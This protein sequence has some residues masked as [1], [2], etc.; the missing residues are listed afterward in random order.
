MASEEKSDDGNDENGHSL[1]LRKPSDK[2]SLIVMVYGPTGVGKTTFAGTFPKPIFLNVERGDES[3]V[4]TPLGDK[5]VIADIENMDDFKEA[6]G[7]IKQGEWGEMFETVVIDSL[8]EW[9]EH[10]MDSILEEQGKNYPTLREWGIAKQRILRMV[11]NIKDLRM[12]LVFICGEKEE[13]DDGVVVKRP[14]LSG[15]DIPQR[16]GAA[17]DVVGYFTAEK[18]ESG[19]IERDIHIEPDRDYYAKHRLGD[20]IESPIEP[21]FDVIQKA[22]EERRDE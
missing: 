21:D 9:Q 5:E 18:D 8:T 6:W 12:N 7:R 15:G 20:H 11:R 3:L 13:T 1:T 10:L 4:D 19:N 14:S 16:V 17:C 22:H 2:D